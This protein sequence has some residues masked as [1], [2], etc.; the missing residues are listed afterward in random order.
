MKVKNTLFSLVL[1]SLLSLAG[2]SQ[3]APPNI[4]METSKGTI[5]IELFDTK[6]PIT[7]QNFRQYTQE[8]YFDGLIFHRVI[9]GFMIQGGGF[10]PGMKKR[11][12]RDPIINEAN[13][14]LKN[15]RG[16]LSMART[17][18]VNSAT[19]QFFLNVKDNRSLDHRSMR[20][21]EYGYA[22]FGKVVTGMEVAD[23][24]VNTP[25]GR[26]G[27]HNDVPKKDILIIK[28]YEKIK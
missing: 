2:F 19:G 20:R 23:A 21:S 11:R 28:M 27:M 5:E 18:D 24:I 10:E 14:G 8:K 4:I 22:V 25:R 1:L 16:T 17:N 13:N 12:G 26:K 9:P 15:K 6:A 3:A 7:C